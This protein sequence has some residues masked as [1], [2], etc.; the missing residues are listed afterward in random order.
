ML[1]A[2]DE[3][4][5]RA[6]VGAK[7][8][9]AGLVV[10]EARDGRESLE[11]ATLRKPDLVVTDLQMPNLSGLQFALQLRANA[12]TANIPVIMLTARG[13]IVPAEELAKTNIKEMMAKP[14]SARTLL[15]KATALLEA[16]NHVEKQQAA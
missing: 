6:V 2:D 13:H 12:A 14:F 3:P 10:I 16:S 7:F 4:H 1:I 5:I 8:R 9:G 15:E 11:L